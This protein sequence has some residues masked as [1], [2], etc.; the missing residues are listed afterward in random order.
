[1]PLNY[2]LLDNKK[3]K[4]I[5]KKIFKNSLKVRERKNINQNKKKIEKK[6]K[7]K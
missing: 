4:K 3:I 2:A 5:G 7:H 1:M 6:I